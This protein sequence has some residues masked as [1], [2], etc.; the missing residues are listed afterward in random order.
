MLVVLRGSNESTQPRPFHGR[1]NASAVLLLP[2][3]A[4]IKKKGGKGISAK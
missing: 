1:H 2:F 4:V 3:L